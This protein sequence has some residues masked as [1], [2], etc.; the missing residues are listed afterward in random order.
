MID[1]PKNLR[2]FLSESDLSFSAT[3]ET[4]PPATDNPMRYPRVFQY[5]MR[6]VQD[7]LINLSP[8]EIDL[9]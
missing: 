9:F 5:H 8:N 3:N 6:R 1:K 4:T 7:P 2:Y